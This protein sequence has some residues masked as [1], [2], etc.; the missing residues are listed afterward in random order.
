MCVCHQHRYYGE[1]IPF[2]SRTEA[3]QNAS[4]LGYFNSAQALADYAEILVHVKTQLNAEHSPVIVIG[5]SY[6]GSE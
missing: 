3:F 6:G 4:T 5:G 2:G 1:S